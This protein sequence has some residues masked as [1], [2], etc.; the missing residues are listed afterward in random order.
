VVEG[1]RGRRRGEEYLVETVLELCYAIDVHG[2][3]IV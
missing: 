3:R 1:E 2:G